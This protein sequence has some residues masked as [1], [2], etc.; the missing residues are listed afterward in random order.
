MQLFRPPSYVA[1][2]LCVVVLGLH[3]AELQL[4]FP[5]QLENPHV[6]DTKQVCGVKHNCFMQALL[7]P[8]VCIPPLPA[9]VSA[10]V[11]PKGPRGTSLN[12]SFN[13]RDHG[14]M[15]V[16]GAIELVQLSVDV[17]DNHQM[18]DPHI[19]VLGSFSMSL[20]HVGFSSV[21]W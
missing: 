19:N 12:S 21:Y 2:P 10:L 6:I 16:D 7:I 17:S 13:L 9:Q 4:N 20:H 1:P 5:I 8:E 3:S 15:F 11:I 14:R 18:K